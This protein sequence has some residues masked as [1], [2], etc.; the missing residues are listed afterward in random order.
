MRLFNRPQAW[1]AEE[2]YLRMTDQDFERA[3]S[4]TV[5]LLVDPKQSV[6]YSAELTGTPVLGDVEI[7]REDVGQPAS[8]PSSPVEIIGLV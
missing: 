4:S 3:L 7:V 6:A 2:H 8:V 5:P 1:L